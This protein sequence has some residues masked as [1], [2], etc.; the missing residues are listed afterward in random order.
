MRQIC[1]SR[2]FA[3][4]NLLAGQTLSSLRRTL[5]LTR[6]QSRTCQTTRTY[7]RTQMVGIHT[8]SMAWQSQTHG[9]TSAMIAFHQNQ[10][11]QTYMSRTSIVTAPTVYR[12]VVSD[13]TLVS[14]TIS[15]MPLWRMLLC[16]TPRWVPNHSYSALPTSITAPTLCSLVS[17][18]V[19]ICE[20]EFL[21]TLV[22]TSL[23]VLRLCEIVDAH[24][25]SRSRTKGARLFLP[26][27]EVSRAG[28][29][30]VSPKFT[31]NLALKWVPYFS[32][33]T[34]AVEWCKIKGMGWTK[35][36]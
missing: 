6:W 33:L 32:L 8:T 35:R 34:F 22:M 1:L 2:V 23:V 29:I 25:S 36:K 15:A 9:W 13:N 18:R 7:Q 3:S 12:W 10:T 11:P 24:R 4:K 20:H 27:W 26:A 14:R 5:C 21:Y 31:S 17:N 19:R 30:V 16:S 28:A